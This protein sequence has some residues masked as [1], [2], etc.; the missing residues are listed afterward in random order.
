[1]IGIGVI[2]YGYWGPNLARCVAETEGCR[3]AGIADFSAAALARAGKRYP[4]LA[5]H[6]DPRA[7]I[8]DPATFI[9]MKVD[10]AR[11]NRSQ[12]LPHPV[13]VFWNATHPPVIERIEL[14][15]GRK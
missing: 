12:L 4:G 5:L 14:A 13:V 2:G 1:M 10:S 7:L 15:A 9:T 6:Q 11:A 3:L 8:D